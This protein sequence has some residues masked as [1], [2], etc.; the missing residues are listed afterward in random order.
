LKGELAMNFVHLVRRRLAIAGELIT[1]FARN[2]R[3][4]VL[5]IIILV[6]LFGMVLVA[7]ESSAIVPLIYTMF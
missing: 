5:P 6:L 3:W 7:A 4:W 1:F 2:K